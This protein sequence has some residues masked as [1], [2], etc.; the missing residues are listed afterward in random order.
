MGIR[1]ITNMSDSEGNVMP[2]YKD[3]D[4]KRIKQYI[5]VCCCG[6]ASRMTGNVAPT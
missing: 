1:Q 2:R 3:G 6:G 5:P 4:K